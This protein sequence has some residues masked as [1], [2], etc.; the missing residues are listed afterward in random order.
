M[1]ITLCS[2]DEFV[3]SGP[4]I[5]TGT[6]ADTGRAHTL[7]AV[8]VDVAVEVL[9]LDVVLTVVVDVPVVV[10]VVTVE[11]MLVVDVSVS[12][13][14]VRVAVVNIQSSTT[15]GAASTPTTEV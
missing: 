14:E 15:G 6:W 7:V 1:R 13:V 10:K 5:P 11:L 3:K 8:V 2:L 12:V 4:R 9:V